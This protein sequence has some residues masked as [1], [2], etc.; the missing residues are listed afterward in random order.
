MAIHRQRTRSGCI[1]PDTDHLAGLKPFIAQRLFKC[2][3]NRFLQ[4]VKIITRMLTRQIVI[5]PI[6]PYPMLAAGILHNATPYFL[7][8]GAIYN[9][10][11][12]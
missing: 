10:R 3:N 12:Y 6:E 4:P 8:I 1:H 9:D 5:M 11:S 7:P 2:P